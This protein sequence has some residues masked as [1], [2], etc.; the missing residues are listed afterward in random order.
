MSLPYVSANAHSNLPPDSRKT[1][2]RVQLVTQLSGATS[3]N[4]PSTTGSELST[5]LEQDQREGSNQ[6]SPSQPLHRVTHLTWFFQGENQHSGN[7]IVCRFIG[8][9]L[10]LGHQGALRDLPNTVGHGEG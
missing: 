7:F 1:Q 5:E 2:R 9:E 10:Q 3:K 4:G 8:E 6:C